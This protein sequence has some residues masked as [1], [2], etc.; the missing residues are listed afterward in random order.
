MN[1]NEL[2]I[3]QMRL[4]DAHRMNFSKL[5]TLLAADEPARISAHVKQF[6]KPDGSAL[7]WIASSVC[8][9]IGR[10][11]WKLAINSI[12]RTGYEGRGPNL[13]VLNDDRKRVPFL[14]TTHG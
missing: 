4:W 6:T 14:W 13:S 12:M 11:S 10:L 2:T 7:L 1:T 9:P 8:F 3:L 5:S